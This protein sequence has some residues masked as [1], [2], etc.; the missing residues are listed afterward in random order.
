MGRRYHVG[1]VAPNGID[2][3]TLVIQARRNIDLMDCEL[4][5]Y[6]GERET[7]KR[8]LYQSRYDI[9]GL[10]NRECGTDFSRVRVD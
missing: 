4:W 6:M 10:V 9:M 7:T 1:L 3:D 5:R 2:G 8:E